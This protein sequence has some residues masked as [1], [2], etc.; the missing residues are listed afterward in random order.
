MLQLFTPRRQCSTVDLASNILGTTLGLLAA[1]VFHQI[2]DIPIA[3]PGL[4]IRDRRAIALLSCWILFLVFPLYPDLWLAAWRAKLSV[5]FAFSASSPS[6]FLMSTAECFAVGRLLVAAGAKTPVRWLLLLFLLL[7]IQFGI[8]THSPKAAEFLGA[9]LGV[10]LFYLFGKA[11]I[12]DGAAGIALLAALALRG[13]APYQFADPARAFVWIPFGGLLGNE[14]QGSVSILLGKSFRYGAS[15]WL[16]GRAGPGDLR[17]ATIV[18]AVLAGVEMLQFWI[19]GH[20]AE[21]TDPLLAVL[22]YLGLRALKRTAPA[23]G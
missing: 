7:P 3:G 20:V 12:A 14:W 11:A 17:A 8:V 13:L 15:I 21:I 1:Y 19:P 5:F 2:A 22:L 23:S 6:Q 4:R 18:A 10:L 16:M 9:A